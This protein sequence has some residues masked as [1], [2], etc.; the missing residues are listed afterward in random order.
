MLCLISSGFRIGVVS[1][2]VAP[3]SCAVDAIVFRRDLPCSSVSSDPIGDDG[4]GVVGLGALS[5][6]KALSSP[7]P[8]DETSR[9]SLWGSM[10]FSL[11]VYVLSVW[12]VLLVDASKY[13]NPL[14]CGLY[15]QQVTD[16]F[17]TITSSQ[18][19]SCCDSGVRFLQ[20]SNVDR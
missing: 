8:S 3:P 10:S 19:D 15:L 5:S 14:L 4:S 20:S 11:L 17:V 6:V 18:P 2:E 13:Y 9:F 12:Y 1:E 16:S 7:S